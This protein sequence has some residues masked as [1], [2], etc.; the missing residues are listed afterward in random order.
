MAGVNESG[1]SVPTHHD[2][3]GHSLPVGVSLQHLK[4]QAKALRKAGSATSNADAQFQI[5]RKYGFASW[6]KVKAH[7]ET[8]GPKMLRSEPVLPVSN[9][10]I[11]REWYEQTLEFK[12]AYLHNNPPEDVDGNYANLRRDGVILSLVLCEPPHQ[13]PWLTPGTQNV[14]I[15]VHGVEAIHARIVD[16]GI[17]ITRK[18]QTEPWGARAFAVR[19]P[20]GNQ[21]YLIEFSVGS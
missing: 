16:R 21:V 20:D 11:A 4:D 3:S 9:M 1:F 7:F 19:D 15:Y 18:L 17:S 12:T 8:P 13:L 10:R 2:Q 5:A 14:T 6:P